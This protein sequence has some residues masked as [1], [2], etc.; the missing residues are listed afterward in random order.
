MKDL[1]ISE[2]GTDFMFNL[3]GNLLFGEANVK[4]VA[5]ETL[6]RLNADSF[7]DWSILKKL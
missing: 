6:V 2:F 5:I 4:V 1:K 7:L 3:H